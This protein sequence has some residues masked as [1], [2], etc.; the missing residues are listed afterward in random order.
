[1]PREIPSKKKAYLDSISTQPVYPILKHDYQY[2]KQR[3]LAL[4]LDLEGGMSVTMQISLNEL[5]KK[6]SNNN[7]DVVFNQASKTM[8]RLIPKPASRILSPCLLMNMKSLILTV[9]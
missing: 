2:V 1:M 7:A 9:S 6:L 4:G 8:H 3:E 5:V